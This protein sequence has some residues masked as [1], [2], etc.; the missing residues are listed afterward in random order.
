MTD[1]LA[2]ISSCF[3]HFL[4]FIG[5]S[6]CIRRRYCE[7]ERSTGYTDFCSDRGGLLELELGFGFDGSEIYGECFVSLEL[8]QLDCR[9]FDCVAKFVVGIYFFWILLLLCSSLDRDMQ[10]DRCKSHVWSRGWCCVR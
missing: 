9:T 4:S 2:H 5:E 1:R 7:Y 8:L 10:I 6:F 3:S